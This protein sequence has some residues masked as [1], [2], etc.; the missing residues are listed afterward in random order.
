MIDLKIN[1]KPFSE[2]KHYSGTYSCDCSQ[3]EDEYQEEFYDFTAVVT[4]DNENQTVH[5]EEIT[6]VNRIPRDVDTIEDYINENF[7]EIIKL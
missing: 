2:T 3:W 5:L 4:C 1:K 6:W 7:F